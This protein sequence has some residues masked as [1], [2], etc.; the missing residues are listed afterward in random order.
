MHDAGFYASVVDD[1]Q[2]AG[3]SV[4]AKCVAASLLPLYTPKVAWKKNLDLPGLLVPRWRWFPARY[5]FYSL[6]HR[7]FYNVTSSTDITFDYFFLLQGD[8]R[9]GDMIGMFKE[10]P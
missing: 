6:Y 9:G 1:S 5:L 8:R 10:A 2:R 3:I 4:F 7:Y